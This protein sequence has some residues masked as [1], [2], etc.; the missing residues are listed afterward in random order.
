VAGSSFGEAFRVTTFGESHGRA[1]GVVIDGCPPG[2]EVSVEEIQKELDRRR[3]GRGP[4]TTPRREE[5]RV[6]VL[7]G[8]FEEK[9]LGTPIALLVYNQEIDSTPYRELKGKP[10]PGHADFTYRAKYGHVDWRGGGRASA[11]ETVGRVAAGAVAKRLLATKGIEILGHAVEIHGVR[12]GE[13]GPE[14]IRERA[15]ESPVRC[16]DPKASRKMEEEI[17]KAKAEGDSVGGVIEVLALGVPPGLGEPVFD[18][19]DAEIAKAL[20][21]IGSVKGVEIG[22]GFESSRKRGSENNDPFYLEGGRVKTR[23]NHAGGILGG[24]SNG[25]PI[26]VRAAIKPTSSIAREQ[27]TVDLEA[28]KGTTIAVKGRHDPCIVP[29]VLPVAEAMLALVLADH[30]LR[31]GKG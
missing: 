9:T 15:E 1:V 4:F 5:D 21:S 25:M 7:S 27:K 30:L 2:L 23:T 11:R 28:E 18:K 19:L 14:E 8:I 31:S 3:P 12:A 26:V 17:L 20:V 13:V 29:R 10:R 24:I 22:S 6:E 16:A